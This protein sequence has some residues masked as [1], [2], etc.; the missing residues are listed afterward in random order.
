MSCDDNDR[1]ILS[2]PLG[3]KYQFDNSKLLTRRY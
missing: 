2:L 3:H 1:K